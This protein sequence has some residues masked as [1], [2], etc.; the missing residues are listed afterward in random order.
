[1]TPMRRLLAALALALLTLPA[2]AAPQPDEI[3]DD[4]ALEAR[5]RALSA[6]LRCVVCRTESIDDSDAPLA[7]DMRLILRERLVE[8]DSDAQAVQFLVD[9]Y[10]EYILLNPR[11]EGANLI[12]WA[13]GPLM[14]LIALGIAAAA[15]RRRTA[16]A[17]APLSA[18]EEARL[19]A[20]MKD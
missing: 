14:L 6:G 2:L 4:P 7:R 19:K 13:S 15:F 3:L 16:P 20:L 12:L 5:A 1:M 18:E 10:G 11:R 9:R 17:P 8:G